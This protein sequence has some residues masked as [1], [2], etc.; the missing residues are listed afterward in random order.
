MWSTKCPSCILVDFC[1][2]VV[3]T[4]CLTATDTFQPE[5]DRVVY[6]LVHPNNYW[7]P[8]RGQLGGYWELLKRFYQTEGIRNKFRVLFMGPGWLSGKPRLGDGVPEVFGYTH[9]ARM[10]M[11]TSLSGYLLL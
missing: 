5:Q 2:V 4:L 6:G 7:N 1:S 10:D 9:N 3:N 11:N 8:L